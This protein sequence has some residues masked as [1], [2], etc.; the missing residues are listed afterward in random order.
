MS[1]PLQVDPADLDAFSSRMRELAE[2]N[3]SAR[4]YLGEWLNLSTASGRIFFAVT[5]AIQKARDRLDANYAQLGKL[6][7]SSSTE[8]SK[9]ARMYRGQDQGNSGNLDRTYRG[10]R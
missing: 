3:E 9:N 1:D 5:E 8:L 2:Q 4:D 10:G 7:E 6:A